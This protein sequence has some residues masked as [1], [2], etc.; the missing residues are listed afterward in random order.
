[1]MPG[2][3]GGM[4]DGA[5]ATFSRG[6]SDISGAVLARA[7]GSRVYENWTDVSGVLAADPR[8]IAAPPPIAT[9]TYA[10]VRELAYLGATVLHE[11]AIYPAKAA[12]DSHSHLQHH[13]PPG[14][15][16]LDRG[17]GHGACRGHHRPGR[18]AGLLRPSGGKGAVQQR[19]GLLPENS[20]LPGEKRRAI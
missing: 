2:F 11:D 9:M 1:M 8:V 12:R 15:R 14:S 5:V 3:Y 19:G 7:S 16:H 18:P 10:E 13:G 4:P 20:V 17:P 6:G